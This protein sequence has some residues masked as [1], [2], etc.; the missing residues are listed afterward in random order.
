MSLI[1]FPVSVIVTN[2]LR[3]GWLANKSA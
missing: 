1:C 3:N 2:W